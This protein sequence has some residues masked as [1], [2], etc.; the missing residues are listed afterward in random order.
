MREYIIY[1]R[2][3]ENFIIDL[4]SFLI[5]LIV[6]LFFYSTKYI[7]KRKLIFF[8]FYSS[9]PL[10]F[11]DFL[12]SSASMWDQ[13]TYTYHLIDF[14]SIFGTYEYFNYYIENF[15][16][17]LKK[18]YL[19]SH[20]YGIF[21][22][23]NEYSI[24]TIAFINKL[25][26]SL[27]SI[28]LLKKKYIKTSHLFFLLLFPSTIIYSSLSLK[29]IMLAVSSCWIIIFLHE[30][31][32]LLSIL[33]LAI[34]FFLR[35]LFY[36][37]IGIFLIYFFITN[38]LIKEK[39]IEII[40]NLSIISFLFIF[41]QDIIDLLNYYIIVYNQEDA[42]WGVVLNYSDLNFVNYSFSSILTNFKIVFDKLI[43]NW[44]M[45]LQFKI[46]FIL[47]NIMLFIFIFKYFKSDL[48]FHKKKTIISYIF[49]IS[50]I[51]LFYIIFPNMLPLHR[52]IYPFLFFFVILNKFKFRNENFTYHK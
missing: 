32:Y 25:V 28:Y 19:G 36:T 15:K 27:T 33:T 12:F 5:I 39:T 45:P 48:K 35:P 6:F 17:H 18:I 38:N 47:E 20:I 43:L 8:S 46:L 24:N 4:S 9:T 37:Y 29:E 3:L 23:F 11:N 49:L 30:R 22:F 14:N 44:P 10:F 1:S 16:P 26:L 41:S 13:Y 42:G 40:F 52:Y 2:S 51:I 21:F 7:D 34:F 31:K 50:S